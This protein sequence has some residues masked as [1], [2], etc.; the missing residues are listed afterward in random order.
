MA[1]LNILAFEKYKVPIYKAATNTIWHIISMIGCAITNR[2][3]KPHSIQ[4]ND[5]P[6]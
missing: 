1:S 4:I 6:K 3:M 5:I 2:S